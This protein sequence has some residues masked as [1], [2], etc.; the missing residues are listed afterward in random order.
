MQLIKV[1]IIRLLIFWSY[2]PFLVLT[3]D[4]NYGTFQFSET[5]KK[6]ILSSRF[7]ILNIMLGAYT[8]YFFT[9]DISNKKFNFVEIKSLNKLYEEDKHVIDITNKYFIHLEEMPSEEVIETE[10]EF[11]KY[12][13][14]SE[15]KRTVSSN[16]KINLYATIILT[17]LPIVIALIDL[18]QFLEMNWLGKLLIFIIVYGLLNI[19]CYIFQSISIQ[20]IQRS[21]FNDLKQSSD[22]LLKLNSLYYYDWQM[23][24]RKADLAVSYVKN[25]QYWFYFVTFFLTILFIYSMLLRY[26]AIDSSPEDVEKVLINL[27]VKLKVI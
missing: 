3:S 10:K 1:S 5:F 15:E 19:I 8:C 23:F 17:V 4:K 24:K 11:L 13:I 18:K 9:Y 22:H 2:S 27:Q 26:N 25:I 6:S 21:T 20:F 14:E 7:S 12:K 16:T